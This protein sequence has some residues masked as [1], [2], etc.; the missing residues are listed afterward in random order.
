MEN[1]KSLLNN[2][3]QKKNM[4]LPIYNN[5][6]VGGSDHDPLWKTIIYFSETLQFQGSHEKCK[7]NSESVAASRA[8]LYFTTN[9][10]SLTTIV[11]EEEEE[12]EERIGLFIDMENMPN[13]LSQI[14]EET[15]SRLTTIF[16]FVG[17]HHP[18]ATI[19]YPEYVTLIIS[20]STR[21]DGTDTCMQVFIG[22]LLKEKAY[23]EY[24]IVTR[25]HFGGALVD[26]I[27][28][29]NMPWS[30]A[31]ARIATNNKHLL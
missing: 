21:T 12:E 25:D 16:V 6:R 22:L 27:T 23:D 15:R 11:E 19:K 26:M 29:S 2:Y 5:I 7:K 3:L 9:E 4:P 17:E 28:A 20:P 31:K 24:I 10:R 14:K 8:L 18:K 13:F 1:H 30:P